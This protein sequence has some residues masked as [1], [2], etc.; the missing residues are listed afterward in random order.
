[1]KK[2]K[3]IGNGEKYN[4]EFQVKYWVNQ[5]VKTICQAINLNTIDWSEAVAVDI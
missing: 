4:A 2:K 3:T 1:M 5:D